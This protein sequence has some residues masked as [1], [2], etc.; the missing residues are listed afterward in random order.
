MIRKSLTV[1]SEKRLRPRQATSGPLS[2]M[3]QL[4]SR[5][6]S[7]ALA[8][9]LASGPARDRESVTDLAHKL[10]LSLQEAARLS[11]LS[12]ASLR[13]AIKAGKLKARII[14]RGYRVKRSDLD[15]YVR[16]I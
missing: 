7:H 2:H 9:W 6:P 14:G 3:A 5:R 16:K 11:G 12:R 10:T 4:Q 13:A 15:V 1:S 8:A